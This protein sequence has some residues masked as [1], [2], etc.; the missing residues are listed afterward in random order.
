VTVQALPAP[1]RRPGRR[2]RRSDWWVPLP[3]IALSLI[4]IVFGTLRLIEVFGGPHVMPAN[5]RIAA[6][7]SP[8]VVHVLGGGLFLLLGAFQLSRRIRNRWLTWHR[9]SGRVLMT[10]GLAAALAGLWMTLLYPRQTGTGS[11]LH[12]S[13]VLFA[14]TMAASIVLGYRAIRRRDLDQ[15]RAWMMR[16]YALGLGA[17]TQ[18]I[19]IGLGEGIFGKT[20]LTTDLS[21]AS[22]WFINIAVAEFLIRRPARRQRHEAARRTAPGE[23]RCPSR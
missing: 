23:A 17:G 20:V 7:P 6:S 1:P 18:A 12:V 11:I 4:P 10:L 3:L 13:R 16:A 21:T 15:H 14:S 22:G 19:T 2:T 5:P 9:R 8:A